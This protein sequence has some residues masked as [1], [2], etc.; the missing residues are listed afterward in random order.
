MNVMHVLERLERFVVEMKGCR[1][2]TVMGCGTAVHRFWTFKV[3]CV[4]F[5]TK[6]VS[7]SGAFIK[8]HSVCYSCQRTHSGNITTAAVQ[9]LNIR[10]MQSCVLMC[11]CTYTAVRLQANANGHI[12]VSNPQL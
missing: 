12:S 3:L 9:L 10:S 4:M 11:I 8:V 5:L 1:L 7:V 6:Y 2:A